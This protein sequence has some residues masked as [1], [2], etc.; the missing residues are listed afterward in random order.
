MMS[1]ET[2]DLAYTP[3]VVGILHTGYVASELLHFVRHLPEFVRLEMP[4]GHQIPAQRNYCVQAM[5]AYKQAEWLCFIDSDTLPGYT[6]IPGLLAA[7][8][9]IVSALVLER[10]PPFHVN[11][12]KS[13]EPPV[14]W[15]LRELPVD[16]C[17][18]A[19]AVGAGCLLIRRRVFETMPGPY[20]F[21]A[22]W[23]RRRPDQLREDTGFTID[24]AEHGFHAWVECGERVGHKLGPGEV[25]FPGTDGL[26]W[27]DYGNGFR[28]A[29][30]LSVAERQVREARQAAQGATAHA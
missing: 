21:K 11:A 24:A 8:M 4:R 7:E 9:D 16:G 28:G 3:G 1:R 18:R 14:R 23:D 19:L 6:T 29:I 25:V 26:A 30:D 20:W 22:G 5:L 12:V 17:V 2:R 27:I 15:L 10:H 13:F